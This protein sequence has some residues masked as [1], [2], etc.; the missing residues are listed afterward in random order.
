MKE[1]GYC[2]W[3]AD[4]NR[5]PGKPRAP[6]TAKWHLHQPRPSKMAEYL[7]GQAVV[8]QDY[9]N[10]DVQLEDLR[11]LTSVSTVGVDPEAE[12]PGGAHPDD[13]IDGVKAAYQG[14]QMLAEGLG[15]ME[16]ALR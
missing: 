16:K 8:D 12:R 11:I 1:D 7:G 3:L 13:L 14:A 10:P 6:Y 4:Y 2:H 5:S 9:V 15:R